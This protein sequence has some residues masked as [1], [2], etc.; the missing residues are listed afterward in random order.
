MLENLLEVLN[1]FLELIYDRIN[2]FYEENI[3]VSFIKKKFYIFY[4][5]QIWNNIWKKKK[6]SN[7]FEI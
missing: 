7:D 2:M 6:I 1:I 5:T 3:R 4:Y